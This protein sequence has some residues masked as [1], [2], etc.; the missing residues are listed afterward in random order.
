MYIPKEKTKNTEDTD[1]AKKTTWVARGLKAEKPGRLVWA[2]LKEF[3]SAAEA[4]NWLCE[5]VRSNGLSIEDFRVSR[6]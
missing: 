5:Y 3:N 6:R 2:D 1:M 4:D